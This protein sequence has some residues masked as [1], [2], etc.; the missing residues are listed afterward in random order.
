MTPEFTAGGPDGWKPASSVQTPPSWAA[1]HE[2][3]RACRCVNEKQRRGLASTRTPAVPSTETRQ[4]SI[5][6]T[7]RWLQT[8]AVRFNYN[9]NIRK[10]TLLVWAPLPG[11]GP[12]L[13]RTTSW[14]HKDRD[15]L[16]PAA[17]GYDSWLCHWQFLPSD[18]WPSL[19]LVFNKP[20]FFCLFCVLVGAK[21]S[22]CAQRCPLQ[23]LKLEQLVWSWSRFQAA[24]IRDEASSQT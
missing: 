23:M 3:L 5:C 1:Q 2:N 14:P 7:G 6:W 4:T 15:A 19:L 22:R 20:C 8:A 11:N 12:Q 18:T 17:P 21:A 24:R 9:S 16:P 13:G 10:T